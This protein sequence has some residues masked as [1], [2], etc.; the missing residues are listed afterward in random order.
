MIVGVGVVMLHSEC[1]AELVGQ[2]RQEVETAIFQFEPKIPIL[3]ELYLG[4]EAFELRHVKAIVLPSI[5]ARASIKGVLGRIGLFSNSS[6]M[7]NVAFWSHVTGTTCGGR[8]ILYPPSLVWLR[9]AMKRRTAGVRSASLS[10]SAA[11]Q[12][13]RAPWKPFLTSAAKASR[14]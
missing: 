2:D 1:V 7:M 12:S 5:L 8:S 9:D 14:S 6:L 3:Y 11:D 10:A 4:S 13:I